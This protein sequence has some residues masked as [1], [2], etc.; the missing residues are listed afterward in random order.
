MRMARENCLL[1][2]SEC[3]Y[4][5]TYCLFSI[6][7]KNHCSSNSIPS[8]VYHSMGKDY[9]HTLQLTRSAKDNDIKAA[10]VP[11]NIFIKQFHFFSSY[12][13]L[14][15]K[16]HPVKNN[17]DHNAH[18]KFNELAEAF[19][20]L[21]DRRYLSRMNTY[22]PLIISFRQKTSDLRSVRR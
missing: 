14:A 9:Y 8:I 2:H 22:S 15:L 21:S 18:N 4:K 13:R 5:V 16:Y 20:V 12:R 10:Y 7:I 3:S 11:M 17:N 6:N 19:E 1:L